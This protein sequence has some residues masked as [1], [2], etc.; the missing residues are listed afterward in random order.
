MQGTDD[1]GVL[2]GEFSKWAMGKT[3]NRFFIVGSFGYCRVEAQSVE[4]GD[5]CFEATWRASKQLSVVRALLVASNL[6]LFGTGAREFGQPDK[7]S[8]Q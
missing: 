1:L 2:F 3:N 8:C 5:E 6:G 7:H 4:S